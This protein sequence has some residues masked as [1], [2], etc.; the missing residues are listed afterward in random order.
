MEALILVPPPPRT[1]TLPDLEP[2][3]QVRSPHLGRV[4]SPSWGGCSMNSPQTVPFHACF[5]PTTVRR[6]SP[7]SQASEAPAAAGLTIDP[8]FQRRAGDLTRGLD[9]CHALSEVLRE[10]VIKCQR[11]MAT[12]GGG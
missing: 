4:R 9:D 8:D 7:R 5:I 10:E 11:L 3:M 6:F 1:I 12:Q 2:W